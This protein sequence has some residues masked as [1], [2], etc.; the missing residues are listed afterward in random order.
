MILRFQMAAHQQLFTRRPAPPDDIADAVDM[1]IQ[2]RLGQPSD[3]PMAGVHILLGE[4]RSMDTGL[5]G[6]D[7]T[8]G[9]QIAQQPLAIDVGHGSLHQDGAVQHTPAVPSIGASRRIAIGALD[10][11]MSHPLS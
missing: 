3:Q 7:V 10:D 5:V 2:A 9:I 6:A 8:Q 4:G 11:W 1:R